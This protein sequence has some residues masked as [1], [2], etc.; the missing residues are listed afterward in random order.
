M[1]NRSASPIVLHLL[2]LFAFSAL[3]ITVAGQQTPRISSALPD[4]IAKI[5]SKKCM[6]CHSSDGGFKSRV[7]LNF[8][9]WGDYSEREKRIKAELMYKKLSKNEMPPKKAREK[10]PEI[11]PTSQD[12]NIIKNWSETFSSARQ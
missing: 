10:N 8:S 9:N 7:K 1:E 6:P 11:I 2:L 5:V 4:S 3:S 12:I